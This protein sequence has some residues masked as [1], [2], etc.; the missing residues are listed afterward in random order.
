MARPRGA[1]RRRPET[2]L[3]LARRPDDDRTL[4]PTHPRPMLSAGDDARHCGRIVRAHARTFALASHFLPPHKRRSA[5]ALYAFCRVADDLV[6]EA[7][8]GEKTRAAQALADYRRRLDA[9]LDGRPDD[10]IFRE[11][12]RVVRAHG[13]PP[14]VLHGLLDGVARD[15]DPVWYES[16]AELGEYCAGV[17][18]TV[19]E[20]CTFVFGVAGENA[21]GARDDVR[22]RALCHARTLGVA[23]QLTNILRDVGED[24]RRGRCYLPADEL[25][26]VG[27]CPDTV[28]AAARGDAAPLAADPRWRELMRFQLARARALYAAAEPGIGLLAEDARRC[29]AACATGYAA[30]LDVIEARH[31]DTLG[32]RARVPAV[33]RAGILWRVWR[34]GYD[35]RATAAG[36][37][38]HEPLATWEQL[39]GERL[40][41]QPRSVA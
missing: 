39:T 1:A 27:L 26:A 15:L 31:Y 12:A 4:D 22:D 33:A 5:F 9:A 36:R 37:A 18:S 35:G 38:A 11:V 17:A 10:A 24:G 34:A 32:A 16:W 2:D 8:P 6:D 19:G 30:I 7:A 40:R 14:A 29:A 3:Y 21:G 23:M 13:V 25:A 20:M 41:P 28:L